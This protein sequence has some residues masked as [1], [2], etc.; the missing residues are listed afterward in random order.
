[1]MIGEKGIKLSEEKGKEL[2][3]PGLFIFNLK[4]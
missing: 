1:M 4:F 2:A 3:L